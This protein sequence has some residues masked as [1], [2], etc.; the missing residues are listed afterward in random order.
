MGIEKCLV[1]T[2]FSL[3]QL[4]LLMDSTVVKLKYSGPNSCMP[5]ISPA[6]L[7]PEKAEMMQPL[8]SEAS[9]VSSDSELEIPGQFSSDGESPVVS[10]S[11]WTDNDERE[12]NQPTE[13]DG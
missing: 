10:E 8:P 7:T 12:T 13:T 4:L 9:E 11:E 3:L 6:P 5:C 1:T 2:V